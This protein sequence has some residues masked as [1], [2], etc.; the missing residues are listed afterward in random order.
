MKLPF[1]W[2]WPT[3]AGLFTVTALI[4]GPDLSIAGPLAALAIFFAG[5]SIWSVLSRNP[6]TFAPDPR[7]ASTPIRGARDFLLAGR[8]GREDLIFRLDWLERHS[9][10]ADVKTRAVGELE[11]VL[12]AAEPEF[13]DY[14]RDRLTRLEESV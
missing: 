13:R 12:D 6:A 8:V 5:I 14:L 1:G 3:L 4:A 10:T 9:P 7:D 2:A 11:R